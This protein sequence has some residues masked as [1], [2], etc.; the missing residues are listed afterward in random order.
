[1]VVGVPPG[2]PERIEP[3]PAVGWNDIPDALVRQSASMAFCN[4]PL[5]IIGHFEIK[6]P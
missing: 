6:T 5:S 4:I 2:S 3:I 1:V